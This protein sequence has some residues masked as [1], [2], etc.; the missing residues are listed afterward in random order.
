MGEKLL[1]LVASEVSD[2]KVVYWGHNYHVG[3]EAFPDKPPTFGHVL[4]EGYGDAYLALALEYGDGRYLA[5]SLGPDGLADLQI[6]SIP[7]PPEG[8]LPWYLVNADIGEFILMLREPVDESEVERWL[9]TPLLAHAMGWVATDPKSEYEPA[10]V[11][12][13][14]DGIIFT[15]KSTPVNPTSTARDNS[16]RGLWL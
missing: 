7:P 11:R 15:R 12:L 3:V 10:T 1:S 9:T 13:R 14:Y 4:R 16:A 8:T 6:V 5:R 2:R